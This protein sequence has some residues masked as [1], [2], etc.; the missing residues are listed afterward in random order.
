MKALFERRVNYV[1]TPHNY[2]VAVV[3]IYFLWI[4]IWA[5]STGSNWCLYWGNPHTGIGWRDSNSLVD[6]LTEAIECV[7]TKGYKLN[8]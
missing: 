5:T 6:L 7:V 4:P 2:G 3:T 1:K 8:V